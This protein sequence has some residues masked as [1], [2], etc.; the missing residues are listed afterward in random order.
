MLGNLSRG[1]TVF[2][3]EQINQSIT[4][5]PGC[6]YLFLC[7]SPTLHRQDLGR[8]AAK[9]LLHDIILGQL[10]LDKGVNKY[11]RLNEVWGLK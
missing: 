5:L 11:E 1:K 10:D 8:G 6:L 9:Y 7:I 4:K 3:F 2:A